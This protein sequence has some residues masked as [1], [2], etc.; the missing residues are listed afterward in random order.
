MKRRTFLILS[1]LGLLPS[2][3]NGSSPQDRNVRLSKTPWSNLRLWYE[4][5]AREWN[6]ALPIG[7]GRLAAMVSGGAGFERIQL[8]EETVWAGEKRDRIN[9]EAA[10]NLAEVR[11]LLFAGKPKEAEILAER[12]MISIPKRM[13]PYQPLGDLLLNYFTQG[14]ATD[15]KRELDLD[16]AIASVSY[17]AGGVRFSREVFAS[18]VDQVIVVRI[19]ADKPKSVSIALTL[20]RARD[21]KTITEQPDVVMIEGEAITR[22]ER[23]ALE[24]KVGVKFIG[25]AK[26][27]AD[28]GTTL[29]TGDEVQVKNADSATLLFAATTDF[30]EKD[31]AARCRQYLAAAGRKTYKQLRA[32]HISDHGRLFRRVELDLNGAKSTLPTDARLKRVEAGETDLDL[33]ALYFQ[34]GRYLLISSSR[35]GSMAANLQ[36]KWNDNLEPAWD[37]KYTI[38][39]NTEMNYWPAEVCNLSELHEPLFD[40]VENA[41]D[42]GRR[43]AKHMYGA[44]GFVIHHNTDLWGHAVPIDGVHA[45]IWPMGAAW[46]SLHYWDHY[47]Y[48]RDRQFLQRRAYPVM[49]EAAEFLIEYLVDDG[50]GHL[51]T[52]PSLSPENQYKAPDGEAV[53]LCMGPSMDSQI[54][55]ALFSRVIEAS[56][57]LGV[58][59][60][61]RQKLISARARLVPPKIGKLGQLMEWLKDYDEPQPGHRH[62]SHLFA[63]HPGDQI[64]VRRTPELARAA[65]VSLERRL[66]AGSGHTGWSRAWIIN[67]WARLEEGDL[68]HEN[69]QALLAK[70]T[71][72]NLLD[73]HPPFQIDGNFGGT[74]GMAE[75]LLQSHSGEISFLPALPK[76]WRN[77]SVK[78]LRARGGVEVDL[79]WRD[80]KANIAKLRPKVDGDFGLRPPRG[81]RI[82][83]FAVD[84]RRVKLPRNGALTSIVLVAGREYS[85][86]F[87]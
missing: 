40:L 81:Q 34:F 86:S 54:T 48:T 82:V 13:P 73:N 27:V 2:S 35:P 60:E 70:S 28:G 36:G 23:H 57:L 3:F 87:E 58:D 4:Q 84:R 29:V 17:L 38:N 12:T 71:L 6:E 14:T 44:G 61:F 68:A 11:R 18:A 64:T 45:G 72:P 22:S 39:I 50:E 76:A 21:S 53:K 52:G 80:G 9:P 55:H 63:L 19:T 8:N 69:I 85:L 32:A 1:A 46:L 24:R 25:M 10:N 47:D 78:G 65:R 67:F 56:E 5:P 51:I 42:D 49:K 43:V 33:E 77:G 26:L 30:R 7:N 62:I 59:R 83:G 74:A 16:T 31:K 15:Y 20:K 37:S 75:M 41:R 66:Q 79:T